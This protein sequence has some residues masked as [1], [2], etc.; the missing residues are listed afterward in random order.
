[1]DLD[2]TS[3]GVNWNMDI[4]GFASHVNLNPSDVISLTITAALAI[5]VFYD[6][7]KNN[8]NRNTK[9]AM[10]LLCSIKVYSEKSKVLRDHLNQKGTQEGQKKR[11]Q[12]MLLCM[13]RD[14]D[15]MYKCKSILAKHE[16]S[17]KKTMAARIHD[18]MTDN[19]RTELA[20]AKL[21]IDESIRNLAFYMI[22]EDFERR[23]NDQPVNKFLTSFE[24]K[25]Y[26]ISRIGPKIESIDIDTF[27]RAYQDF[28]I[29]SHGWD[30][31]KVGEIISFQ[32]LRNVVGSTIDI[33]S[34]PDEI[35]LAEFDN[36][37][38]RF[39][40]LSRSFLKMASLCDKQGFLLP[41]FAPVEKLS[42]TRWQLDYPRKK[43]VLRLSGKV[44]NFT[45]QIAKSATDERGLRIALD[46]DGNLFFQMRRYLII[47]SRHVS[48]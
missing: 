28:L 2:L 42:G 17:Q 12:T 9:T 30:G 34:N 14:A 4:D 19:E 33:G 40:P 8:V 27:T 43:W 1:M 35:S 21:Q 46:S 31:S 5:Y 38:K 44:E 47:M 7:I 16:D 32:V 15:L 37:T 23:L 39:K 36:F 41:W 20:N 22:F 10:D 13:K 18:A 29:E 48:H 24:A 45:L 25:N 3:S 26:W 6:R 11:V